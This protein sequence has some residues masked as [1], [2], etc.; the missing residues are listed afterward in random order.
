MTRGCRKLGSRTP[1]DPTGQANAL[2]DVTSPHWFSSFP[3]FRSR[4][5]RLMP[6]IIAAKEARSP[7]SELIPR[8][9]Q[10]LPT[11]INF[12][13][14]DGST[15]RG[16]L[17][18]NTGC[19]G[20]IA[21]DLYPAAGIIATIDKTSERRSWMSTPTGGARHPRIICQRAGN[22]ST[23]P[24]ALDRSLKPVIIVGHLSAVIAS[25]LDTGARSRLAAAPWLLLRA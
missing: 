7:R 20:R 15:T 14:V 25:R 2:S 11:R 5:Q 9:G 1:V 6:A 19:R 22:N 16:P 8:S 4:S 13:L 18:R 17:D 23:R 21:G 10:P 24:V 3:I 12:R